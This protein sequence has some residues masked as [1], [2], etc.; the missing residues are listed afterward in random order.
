M[1]LKGLGDPK[2]GRAAARAGQY[3]VFRRIFGSHMTT[4]VA[5]RDLDRAV[6]LV[7]AR[8]CCLMC[9]EQEHTNC[10]RAIVADHIVARTGFALHHISTSVRASTHEQR[11]YLPG[12][13]AA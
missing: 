7:S 11:T 6:E 12:F 10:H 3:G 9:F 1:H 5:Q 2:P 8:S 13:A 4:D